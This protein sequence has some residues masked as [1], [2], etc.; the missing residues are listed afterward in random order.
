MGPAFYGESIPSP[1]SLTRPILSLLP[2]WYL[3][4]WMLTH[5][6]IGGFH[7][8]PLSLPT[9]YPHTFFNRSNLMKRV[10]W[11]WVGL[12]S[13]GFVSSIISSFSSFSNASAALHACSFLIFFYIQ[14]FRRSNV[15]FPSI[16]TFQAI[17][18]D[19]FL[20]F[21]GGFCLIFS[22]FRSFYSWFP[23]FLFSFFFFFLTSLPLAYRWSL[24]FLLTMSPLRPH[25]R[26][27]P[28]H[29]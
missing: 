10:C 27:R 11:P 5:I 29:M 28:E 22:P 21:D 17:F 15:S 25:R 18:F 23:G 14:L 7:L 13:L 1:A 3:L 16:P 26:L 6:N 8:P 12:W 19:S 20:C 4:H 9:L 24:A 2:S